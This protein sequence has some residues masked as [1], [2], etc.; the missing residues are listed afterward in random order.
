MTVTTADLVGAAAP[1]GLVAPVAQASAA[2]PVDSIV[3]VPVPADASPMMVK[4]D[5]PAAVKLSDCDIA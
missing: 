4:I 5:V 1:V 3:I 2:V